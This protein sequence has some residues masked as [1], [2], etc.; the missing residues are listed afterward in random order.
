MQAT[1]IQ[2]TFYS[3]KYSLHTHMLNYS[4]I[5]LFSI[6]LVDCLCDCGLEIYALKTSSGF[7]VT[8][9]SPCFLSLCL[10][11]MSTSQPQTLMQVSFL[12]PRSI[13][14]ISVFNS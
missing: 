7:C 5:H 10:P 13:L 4:V 8:T 9:Y 3:L 2:M 1:S 12:F 11:S 6:Y 14:T